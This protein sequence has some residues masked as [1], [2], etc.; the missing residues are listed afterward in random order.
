MSVSSISPSKQ[1]SHD[2]IALRE[3]LID[4]LEHSNTQIEFL[5]VAATPLVS[6]ALSASLLTFL[7][8]QLFL[9]SDV[10]STRL[11]AATNVVLLLCMVFISLIIQLMIHRARLRL[12]RINHDLKIKAILECE[13]FTAEQKEHLIFLSHFAVKSQKTIDLIQWLYNRGLF[14]LLYAFIVTTIGILVVINIGEFLLLL[15]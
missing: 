12:A 8:F 3:E 6:V 2:P 11:L 9:N 4:T 14:R 10:L 1:H 7:S 13:Q 5:S 15:R